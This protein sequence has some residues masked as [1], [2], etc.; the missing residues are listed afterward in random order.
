MLR[1]ITGTILFLAVAACGDDRA[2]WPRMVATPTPEEHLEG[3]TL[4]DRSC[5]QCHGPRASGSDVAP[6]LVHRI[7]EP[8]HHADEAFMRAVRF[9]VR[10]H[11]FRFGDMPPQPHVTDEEARKI[12][13]Y[14]R[15]LQREAGID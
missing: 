4:F 11:H 9:G 6:P 2:S 3:E 5:E 14:I 10:G 8:A 1:G 7:Y 13:A 15:W 12:T